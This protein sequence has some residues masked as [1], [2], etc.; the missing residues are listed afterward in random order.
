[1]STPPP[2]PS[3][4]IDTDGQ[5]VLS[6]I[7][8][9]AFTVVAASVAVA[10]FR[11][12]QVLS[13]LTVGAWVAAAAPFV[14]IVLSVIGISVTA[15]SFVSLAVIIVWGVAVMFAVCG[16]FPYPKALHRAYA[17]KYR[18]AGNFYLSQSQNGA[19]FTFFL[20][21]ARHSPW[22]LRI[23]KSI[24]RSLIWKPWA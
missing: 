8:L 12:R 19:A 22:E 3:A 6:V 17:N 5:P 16:K 20:K 1:M 24:L 9:I 14:G 23:Y 11:A 2:P 10:L 21:A 4:P 18:S 7:L 13:K 15:V